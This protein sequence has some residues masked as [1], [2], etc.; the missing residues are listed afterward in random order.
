MPSQKRQRKREGRQARQAAIQ[1]AKRRQ[2]RQRLFIR[3]GIIALVVVVAAALLGVFSGG[4]K[5]TNATKT[6]T[7]T[8][9]VATYGSTPCPPAD[10]S[11]A[12]KTSFSDSFKR[13]IDPTKTY[14]LTFQT[15]AGTFVASLDPKEAPITVNNFVAL[16]EYHYFDGITF[17]RVI[18]SFVIQGGDPLGTGTGGP[19]YKFADELPKAGSY[20]VGSLA[21]ANSGANTNG[22]QFFVITGQQGISLPPNYSLFGQ[23]TSGLDVVSKIEADGLPGGKPKVVHKMVKVTVA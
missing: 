16:A 8:A 1:A 20:K 2:A 19:G 4:G 3:G 10:G 17:H 22:S 11:A 12:R 6:T 13:C 15:D 9:A 7:T 23:V 21:M 18:P 5:K 14:T